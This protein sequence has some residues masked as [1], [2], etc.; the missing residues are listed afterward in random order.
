RLLSFARP[1][2][3]EDLPESLGSFISLIGS[4]ANAGLQMTLT[5]SI[6]AAEGRQSV[7]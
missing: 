6:S 2:E 3:Q 5:A 1:K 7:L 4:P